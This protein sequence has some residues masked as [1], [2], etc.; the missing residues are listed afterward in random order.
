[1]A[2]ADLSPGS[3]ADRVHNHWWWRPGWRIGRRFYT[4]HLT[5]ES[6]DELHRLV[7][8]YQR[9]LGVLPGLDFIP[10]KWLHLTVQGI[11]FVDEVTADDLTRITDA[12]CR[13][14]ATMEPLRLTFDDAFVGD[15]AIVLPPR[16]S[17]GV[18]KL[19]KVIR[20]A[21]ASVWG[22]ENVPENAERFRPHVSV[23]YFAA[24]GAAT[25]YVAAIEAV[26][27][28]PAQVTI[29]AASLIELNRDHRMYQWT[30]HAR[31]PFAAG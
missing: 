10:A 5:F 7:A 6:A 3:H 13:E 16:D 2:F 19:R 9:A 12:V 14:L 4:W 20:D 24:D 29:P 26:S 21:I 22:A 31:A 17:A 30:T 8:S 15:E 11:G 28:A 23:A 18:V 25:P 1:M 27:P